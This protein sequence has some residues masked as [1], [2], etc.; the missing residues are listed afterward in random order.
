MNCLHKEYPNNPHSH[1]CNTPLSTLSKKK[2]GTISIP[3]LLYP[4]LSIRHQLSM[5][6]Q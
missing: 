6:C 3:C 1:E 4:K 2:S 5:L